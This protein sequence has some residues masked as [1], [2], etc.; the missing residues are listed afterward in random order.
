MKKI[1]F[2]LMLLSCSLGVGA[3]QISEFQAASIARKYFPQSSIKAIK[4]TG[5]TAG[6]AE[7]YIFNNENDNGFIIVSGDDG[8]T[9]VVGYSPQGHF[10]TNCELPPNL[11][12]WLN[13]YADYVKDIRSEK[14]QPLKKYLESQTTPVVDHLLT[15]FWDQNDPY[16]L[17][18]PSNYPTGCIATAFA[19]VMNY[20]EWPE[21]GQGS[22]TYTEEKSGVTHSVDFSQSHYQWANMKDE[23][24]TDNLGA[25]NWTKADE[26][27]VSKLI[28]DCGVAV[29]MEYTRSDSHSSDC[30]VNYA[31]PT[32][33]KYDSEFYT[34]NSMSTERFVNIIK[35]ALDDKKPVIFG[36]QGKSGGHEFVIDGY[37]NNEFL[38]VNWGWSG[39]SDG[40][41]DVNYM[42]PGALGTGGGAGGYSDRQTAIIITPNKTGEAK[43]SQAYLS[44]IDGRFNVGVKSHVKA[45]RQT[46]QKGQTMTIGVVGY[47]N[48]GGP[49]YRGITGVAVYDMK[50]NRLS[51]PKKTEKMSLKPGYFKRNEYTYNLNS[52][53]AAL[54]D[55]NYQ[56]YAVAKEQRPGCEFDWIRV[57]S[58]EHQNIHIEGNT[59]SAKEEDNTNLLEVSRPVTVFA[60]E[61]IKSIELCDDLRFHTFL[62]NSSKEI[63]NGWFKAEIYKYG[64]KKPILSKVGKCQ[65]NAGEE[66]PFDIEFFVDPDRF[67]Y[68]TPYQFVISPV[69]TSNNDVDFQL[70]FDSVYDCVFTIG[71]VSGAEMNKTDKTLKIYPNPAVNSITVET[72]AEILNI[73]LYATDGRLVE[74][75]QDSGTIDVSDCPTGYYII[76]VQTTQ[77]IINRQIIKK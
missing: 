62:R 56:I 28:Y 45:K 58:K 21:V 55:G 17:L 69:F 36:G 11:A 51:T 8:M 1:P 12:N 74:Q 47:W 20:W 76:S 10:P 26:D 57:N 14:T 5:T 22:N 61:E 77:G 7:Y 23:Y 71:G 75:T 33:F 67:Y 46:A 66:K 15:T 16:N 39:M 44:L 24:T 60:N 32:Y 31:A 3:E 40:F 4:T 35:K 29:N 59:I 9:E 6:N 43:S 25:E 68:G 48:T 65:L 41:Y 50:G 34:H 19:Q 37:D 38:H 73:S 30:F 63:A 54:P 13:G 64:D 18:C 53:L 27:A 70:N 49:E 42:N 52:E 2:C 72:N